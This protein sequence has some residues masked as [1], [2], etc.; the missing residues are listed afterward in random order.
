MEETNMN[1]KKLLAL[2][3]A[4][5][6]TLTLVPVT[7]F[8][9]EDPVASAVVSGEEKNFSSLEDALAA[10]DKGTTVKLLSNIDYS[11]TTKNR[12][13]H[14]RD[15]E[16]RVSLNDVTL[17][18]QQHSITTVNA[19][20]VFDGIGTIQN[21]TF[22]LNHI[23]STGAYQAGS[24]ALCIDKP[25]ETGNTNLA[26]KDLVLEG[27][28]NVWS[29]VVTV[30]NVT[31]ETTA[32]QY[33]AVWA[34]DEGTVVTINSGTFTD[35]QTGGKGVLATGTGE[36]AGA[37]IIVKGGYFNAGNK[38]VYASGE[39]DIQISGG[40]FTK[41]P[42][43]YLAD[44]C[45]VV[46][47]DDVNYDYKV[48]K[49][50]YVAQIN[51]TGD[52]Y[53]SLQAA[54][55]AAEAGNTVKLLQDIALDGTTTIEKS[56]TIDGNNKTLTVT[57]NDGGNYALYV[58]ED[59]VEEKLDVAINN[60]TMIT[61]GYQVAVMLNGS[62]CKSTLALNHVDITC[63]GECIYANGHT[64]ASVQDCEF[65]RRGKYTNDPK[66]DAVYFSAL[67]V[68][69]GGKIIASDCKITGDGT[70]VG[71][72]PSGGTV[73]LNNT[74]ITIE[75]LENVEKSGYA[76]WSRN[77]D[78]TNLPGY[79][80]DSVIT[81]HSGEV[82]GEFLITDKYT[83]VDGDKN[84]YD[85]KIVIDGGTFD[86]DPTDYVHTGYE[87]VD[88]GNGT[89]TV[90][91]ANTAVAKIG[92]VKYATLEAAFAA[93]ENGQTIELLTDVT[94]SDAMNVAIADKSVTLNLGNHTLT[95]RTNLKSGNL[96]IQNGTV[97][98]GSEQ[99]LNVY[100]SSDSSA[101]NYSVLNL[102]SDLNVS[103]NSFAVCMFGATATTNGYGAVVNTEATIHTNNNGAIF[104]S[105]NLGQ[106][107]SGDAKNV[108]NV[109]GGS[110]TS[111]NNCA[112]ALN[113]LATVNVTGGTLTGNTAITVKRGTLNVQNGATLVANGEKVD[114]AAANNNGTEMTGAAISV[115]PTY[116][117][118]GGMAVNV[119]GGTITSNNNAALY[120]GHSFDS[121][122]NKTV[123]FTNPVTLNVTGGSF[124]GK[125]G[126]VFVADAIDGDDDMP[127]NF[128][129][130]G[131][132][133]AKPAAAYI[134]DG[135]ATKNIDEKPYYYE[136]SEM[137][138]EEETPV[139]V[140]QKSSLQ[141]GE[142]TDNYNSALQTAN[143]D[144]SNAVTVSGVVLTADATVGTGTDKIT[145]IQ[146]VVN[147]AKDDTDFATALNNAAKV[148]IEVDVRVTPKEYS[149][150]IK[151]FDLT[152]YAK[153]T[154]TK[155]NEET[156]SVN[157]VEVTNAMID[158]DQP[159]YVKLY[160][161]GTT[162][163]IM[164]LHVGE[165][166]TDALLPGD[167]ASLTNFKFADGYCEFYVSHFSDIKA[168]YNANQIGS[169][170]FE[171]ASL[172]R[173]V[174]TDPVGNPTSTV[175][176]NATDIRLEYT[177]NLP[178]NVEIVTSN[179]FFRWSANGGNTWKEVPL[180]NYS[181]NGANL[182]LTGVKHGQ[183]YIEIISELHVEY[184]IQGSDTV[185]TLD[186]NSTE[187]PRS[188]N[189]VCDK[190]MTTDG[191]AQ[192]WKD[193]A[194]FLTEGGTYT[195]ELD[196]DFKPTGEYHYDPLA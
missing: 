64:S 14:D 135:Y 186:A 65:T 128:I 147:A 48:T 196:G 163:P 92:N 166:S 66:K 91:P 160:V 26:L 95:G 81:F 181:S 124:A 118:Y 101:E 145:G 13:A 30:D 194:R 8:A 89:W 84:K 60:L 189:I 93:V 146:A 162:A 22:K 141:T 150:T 11:L 17:D 52:K 154:V 195:V 133:S 185:Y 123:T 156:V 67:V 188:V 182:V 63:D 21:G 121:K 10:A 68:G 39:N 45:K 149:E 44:D 144:G 20:V 69:Y 86:A 130:G 103:A 36:E 51:E 122:N 106:N 9:T 143:V 61:T 56:I 85:A 173:L 105:G 129:S 43:A 99:A 80:C 32:S 172:R 47:S 131:K 62:D 167:E 109:T 171:G 58:N 184:K 126:A 165:N 41:T 177:W 183:F 83:S 4:L 15:E 79:N 16:L 120:V 23:S 142:A 2:L 151:T 29:A 40:Y 119:S 158:Q 27:G 42:E 159:I 116:S 115:T 174:K 107:I 96:T 125:D 164:L 100:G 87:A 138:V 50:S 76:I 53:E 178:E 168:L 12:N 169:L 82:S 140:D 88:N 33:Y 104:V 19:S 7:A 98:G 132:F 25:R 148:E 170:S 24:Y 71:T 57:N 153:V 78:Y 175:V 75:K 46:E 157:G 59:A 179:S 127:A 152:P 90:V 38:L 72:F 31:T 180:K 34:E 117:Q 110:I 113:G 74:D 97:A 28:L 73:T 155:A 77:E 108:I 3:M 114:P 111:D 70:G 102:A 35:T 187:K 37:Q 94:L 190:L 54:I 191:I 6:M 137:T 176:N 134:A 112:I 192:V 55:N 18:L 193:Y 161:G 139:T 1:K 136:V 5:V 49:A